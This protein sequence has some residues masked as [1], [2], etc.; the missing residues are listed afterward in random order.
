[1]SWTFLGLQQYE[2]ERAAYEAD[3]RKRQRFATTDKEAQV[4]RL[5]RMD[6]IRIQEMIGELESCK[7]DPIN[8]LT[9][10]PQAEIPEPRIFKKA[11]RY[12]TVLYDRDEKRSTARPLMIFHERDRDTCLL[13][14]AARF[15]VLLAP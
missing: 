2:I 4:F 3:L 6:W 13:R 9:F 12:F 11:Y 8:E 10:F 1:M 7:D 15:R 5:E 14:M